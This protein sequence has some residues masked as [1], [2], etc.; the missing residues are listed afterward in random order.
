MEKQT[1][2]PWMKIISIIVN[3]NNLSWRH[4]N[5]RPFLVIIVITPVFQI[6]AYRLFYSNTIRVQMHSGIFNWF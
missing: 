1:L 5:Y 6:S 2:S 3:S 4:K